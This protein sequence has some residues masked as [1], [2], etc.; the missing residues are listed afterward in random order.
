MKFKIFRKKIFKASL[1][2]NFHNWWKFFQLKN[3]INSNSKLWKLQF[4]PKMYKITYGN[5]IFISALSNK[6][7]LIK[8]SFEKWRKIH[9]NYC[10]VCLKSLKDQKIREKNRKLLKKVRKYFN[11]LKSLETYRKIVNFFSYLLTYNNNTLRYSSQ[12]LKLKVI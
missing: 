11:N 12:L 9:K 1:K 6:K 5:P 7:S 10:K 2:K 8:F 3:I 4:E